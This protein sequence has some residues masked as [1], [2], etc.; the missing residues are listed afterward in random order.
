MAEPWLSASEIAQHLGVTQDTVYSWIAEKD[1]PSHRVGRL[2][3]F[4]VSE[5]DEWVRRGGCANA[6]DDAPVGTV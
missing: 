3:K 4:Q 5:I 1:M 2:W 6:T